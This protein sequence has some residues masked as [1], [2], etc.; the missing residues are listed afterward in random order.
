LALSVQ[1]ADKST[2][3][4]EGLIAAATIPGI[5]VSH[6]GAVSEGHIRSKWACAKCQTLTQAPVL[7]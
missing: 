5:L 1:Q 7:A 3:G 4:S 6:P 2:S